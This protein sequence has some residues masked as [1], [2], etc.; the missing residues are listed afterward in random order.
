MAV[1]VL[2][3]TFRAGP[4][5]VYRVEGAVAAYLLL[6][7]AWAAAYV[8]VAA[9][10]P[11]AFATARPEPPNSRTFV[12][13]SFVTLTTVGYGDVTPVH[14]AARSLALVEAL[15]GQLYPATLIARIVTLRGESRS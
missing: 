3:Q 6:G 12:Y 8:L 13:F 9:L 14:H 4:V 2:A 15:V 5:S 11:G 10:E 1:V 7:L